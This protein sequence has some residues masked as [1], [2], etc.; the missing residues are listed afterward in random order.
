[1]DSSCVSLRFDNINASSLTAVSVFNEFA[2]I[3]REKQ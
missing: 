3:T 1:M 2:I